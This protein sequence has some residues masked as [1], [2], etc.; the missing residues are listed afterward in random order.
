MQLTHS[1]RIAL[2]TLTASACTADDLSSADRAIL[3]TPCAA[4]ADCPSGFE[5]E[6]EH[7]TSFCQAHDTSGTCPAGYELEIEHGQAYCKPHGGGG[8]GGGGATCATDADC[9]AGQECEV[10]VEHGQTSSYCKPH[11]GA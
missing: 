5:C 7:G 3:D 11:G 2:L 9:P 10:E 4:D 8:G 6:V 1:L